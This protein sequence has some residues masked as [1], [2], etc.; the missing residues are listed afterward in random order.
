MEYHFISKQAFEADL[1]HNKYVGL[2]TQSV[3]C[4]CVSLC[5]SR[6]PLDLW[7]AL[8]EEMGVLERSCGGR[9]IHLSVPI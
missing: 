3:L 1:H 2:P 6:V 7:G 4:S 5:L 8:L 9:C